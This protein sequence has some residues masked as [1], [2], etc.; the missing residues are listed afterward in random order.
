MQSNQAVHF[1]SFFIHKPFFFS[2]STSNAMAPTKIFLLI[3]VLFCTN[4]SPAQHPDEPTRNHL[5][6]FREAYVRSMLER[7][8]EMFLAYYAE[9]I[10]L[11]PEYQKTVRCKN[12]AL[13]YQKAFAGRFEVKDYTREVIET[14]DLGSR[15]VEL[16]TFKMKMKTKSNGKEKELE[17]KYQNIWEKSA[18]AKLSLIT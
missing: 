5:K 14:L 12:H 16:G 9:D 15:V 7:K 6:N 4:F 13:S 18:N 8:P 11:M 17:G 2:L 1:D 10:R 3:A